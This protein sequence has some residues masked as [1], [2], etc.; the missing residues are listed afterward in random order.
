MKCLA[1]AAFAAMLLAAAGAQAAPKPQPPGPRSPT[2]DALFQQGEFEEARTA[3]Q[4]VPKS[5]PQYEE[6]QRQL[7]A[8]ALYQNRLGEAE[9]LLNKARTLNPADLATVGLLAETMH[10]QGRFSEMAQLLKEIGR[11]DRESEFQIFGN[12]EPYRIAAHQ[13]P[14]TVGLQWTDPLPVVLAK[15]NGFQGLF[16]ID[17]GA[18][19]IIL[20]PEFALYAHV[21]SSN[22]QARG[23][24]SRPML[25][26][27]RIQQFTLPGLE[28]DD[29]PAMLLSTRGL[30]PFARNKRIA[31]VIGT[32]FLSHFRPTLDYVHDK[33]ILEP[34]DAPARTGSGTIAE[35]PFWF[36]GDHFL[37]APGRLDNG[38]RQMFLID[39][40][41]VGTAFT[42]P[43]STL[44]SAGIPVPT[45]QGPAKSRIGMPP[46]ALFPITRLSLGNLSQTNL[47]GV[48]GTFPLGLEKGLGVNIGGI[49][50][51]KYL[52]PYAV[53]FDFVRMTIS[54]RK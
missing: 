7:G 32:Q 54:F 14:V 6:A 40:G 3:Y 38:P 10:R 50:S 35:V 49:I 53:T 22:A 36:V 1:G 20:D 42:A 17:T 4:A 45:P 44:Q 34:H 52:L 2:A 9:A 46:S 24:P 5:S 51:H 47:S 48:Y 13:G 16:V 28:T 30:T 29:V 18:P 21:Q 43:A 19:E 33:L 39:S 25:N 11:T 15:V 23:A 37:L 31:G 41:I 8:I 27:G 26:F 12:S